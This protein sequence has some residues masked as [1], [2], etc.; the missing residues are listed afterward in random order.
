MLNDLLQVNNA[1]TQDYSSR[2][3]PVVVYSLR[4]CANALKRNQVVERTL[5]EAGV[6]DLLTLVRQIIDDVGD[7]DF[8]LPLK[9]FLITRLRAVEEALLAVKITGIADV[10]AAV[11]ALILGGMQAAKAE[12]QPGQR[13]RIGGWLM[14][15]WSGLQ[16][17]AKGLSLISAA[18]QDVQDTIKMISG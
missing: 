10:E 14:K 15:V 4:A 13:Q 12:E 8:G 3:T 16:A 6:A 7:S 1:T 5:D 18:S 17:A 9:A 2:V 11:D